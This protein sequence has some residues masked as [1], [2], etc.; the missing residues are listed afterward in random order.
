M[1]HKFKL[2][3]V[4]ELLRRYEQ[5]KIKLDL[6][7]QRIACWGKKSK[8]GYL[9]GILNGGGAGTFILADAKNSSQ[10]LQD[11]YLQTVRDEG[12]DY[13]SIDG[14]NR[15]VALYE[16]VK[17]E[18]PGRMTKNSNILVRFNELTEDQQQAFLD[19]PLVISTF[20]DITLKECSEEFISHNQSKKLSNQEYRN[21]LGYPICKEVRELELAKRPYLKDF[22][23]LAD[24]KERKNDEQILEAICLQDSPSYPTD[25]KRKD[26]FWDRCKSGIYYDTSYLDETLDLIPE[27]CQISKRRGRKNSLITD[28]F[29][30]RG[31]L[32]RHNLSGSLEFYKTFVKTREDLLKNKHLRWDINKVEVTYSEFAKQPNRLDYFRKKYEIL[33]NIVDSYYNLSLV[34]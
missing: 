25:K 6:C 17:N 2:T 11:N 26:D 27:I 32:K 15:T 20:Y 5:G 33:S 8:I 14:N 28:F 34:A 4:R 22:T 30:I 10:D 12:F 23:F 18:V 24:N 9:T 3:T 29:I 7:F 16:F 13:V 1:T 31:I 21:A 19:A